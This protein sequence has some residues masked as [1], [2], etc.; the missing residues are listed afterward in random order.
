V[1]KLVWPTDLHLVKP[2]QAIMISIAA[3]Q[4]L[5]SAE[6]LSLLPHGTLTWQH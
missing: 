4:A 6:I 3:V 5:Y 1:K 2:G